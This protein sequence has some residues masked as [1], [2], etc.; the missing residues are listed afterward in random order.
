MSSFILPAFLIFSVSPIFIGMAIWLI[1]INKKNKKMR[2]NGFMMMMLSL[3]II[4]IFA[5]TIFATVFYAW[6]ISKK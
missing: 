1:G 3:L 5:F 6:L 4:F 2:H